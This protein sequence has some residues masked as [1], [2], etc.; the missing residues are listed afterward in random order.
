[1]PPDS[2]RFHS[3]PRPVRHDARRLR[4]LTWHVHGNY[5]YYLSQVPHDFY[6]VT[7]PGHEPGYAGRAGRLPWGENVHEVP[8]DAVREHSFDCVLFQS[9]THWQS[10]RER[11]LSPAQSRLPTI[12]LEH[13]PP[14]ESPFLQPHWVRDPNVL[15]VHVTPF[16]AMMWDS[17]NT[18]VRIIEHGVLLPKP[19]D[20]TGE[21]ER[22]IVVVNHLRRRGRRLGADVFEDA[23]RHV[24]LDLVGMESDL[25]GGLGEIDNIELPRFMSRY[26]FFFNPIRWTSL[27]LA[28]VEAMAIGMPVVGLATTELAAVIDRG[29]NGYV[30]S[31]LRRLVPVMHALLADRSLA[32]TWGSHA[33]R[34][35]AERFS[36]ERFIVDWKDAFAT[37]SQ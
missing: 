33:R 21:L 24:P 7:K 29:T 2:E 32:K 6:L 4:V 27:G 18:P 37:V 17:G 30:D 9:R 26:R 5:L 12:Y 1:M 13:D 36:I 23:R 19:A 35:A 15:L 10:D 28:V 31:D 22:G 3:S 25:L 16:N 11:V 8:Y 20:Y 34:T 14:Q